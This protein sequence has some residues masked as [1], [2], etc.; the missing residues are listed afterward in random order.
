MA[1][2]C[3]D[4]ITL[5]LRQAKVIGLTRTPKAHESDIGLDVLQSLYRGWFGAGEFGVLNDVYKAADYTA[6]E[7]DR[8]TAETGVTITLP[9]TYEAVSDA[10]GD[11]AGQRRAPRE[12]S[13]IE[14]IQDGSVLSYIWERTGWVEINSLTLDANAPLEHY[15]KGGLAACFA[16]HYADTFGTQIGA[17]TKRLADLFKVSMRTRRVSAGK[18]LA[19]DYA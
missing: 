12:L 6:L 8:V 15:G 2:T 13:A 16:M 17:G 18:R 10:Y 7:Q 19:V 9:T 5:G 11:V 4:I 14:I 3:R 1:D